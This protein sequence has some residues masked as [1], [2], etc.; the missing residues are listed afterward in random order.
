[1]AAPSTGL[2]DDQG[3]RQQQQRGARTRRENAQRQK[4]D[5]PE[6]REPPRRAGPHHARH[7]REDDRDEQEDCLVVA[8]DEK[9]DA[10]PAMRRFIQDRC[11]A[12]PR[13][14]LKHSQDRADHRRRD[15]RPQHYD[16]PARRERRDRQHGCQWHEEREQ[17]GKRGIR[18]KAESVPVLGPSQQRV[19]SN[20][21]VASG[22]GLPPCGRQ[23]DGLQRQHQHGGCEHQQ[24]AAQRG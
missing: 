23:R 5:G 17:R 21:R 12:G 15:D 10:E 3:N 11:A 13:R 20:R 16:A 22:Q 6:Q 7:R 19:D 14:D 4:A 8:V 24:E 1:M 2:P 9:T 18:R